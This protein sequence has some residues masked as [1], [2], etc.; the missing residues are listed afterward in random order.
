M[1]VQPATIGSG[2]VAVEHLL[3][4]SIQLHLSILARLLLP[5]KLKCGAHVVI[6]GS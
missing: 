6:A 1:C 5:W 2:V 4:V 3:V